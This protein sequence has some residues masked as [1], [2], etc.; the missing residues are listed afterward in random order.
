MMAVQ[1]FAALI[2][3]ADGCATFRHPQLVCTLS[4]AASSSLQVRAFAF[5][6]V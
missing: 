6:S 3:S 2:V 4:G 1:C 5:S